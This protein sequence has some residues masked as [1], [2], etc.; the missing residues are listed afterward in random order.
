MA[1]A[2]LADKPTLSEIENRSSRILVVDDYDANIMIA[3][4]YL[5]FFGYEYDIAK[6]GID[7][8]DKVKSNE[9]LAILMDIQMPEMD[10]MEATMKI[11]D[12]EYNE[13]RNRQ[14]IIAMTAH[15][16]AADC[17][18]CFA[19]GMDAYLSKPFNPNELQAMLNHFSTM[20]CR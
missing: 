6:N 5:E 18:A 7:A 13:N 12:M 10:G 9:Y 17:Q 19:V 8:I 20:A 2:A 1:Q 14:P 16:M 11:R 3:S 4:N 15:L